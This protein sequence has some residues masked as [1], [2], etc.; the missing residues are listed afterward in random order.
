MLLKLIVFYDLYHWVGL[1]HCAANKIGMTEIFCFLQ[2]Q[3]TWKILR[4]FKRRR[5]SG[6]SLL[7]LKLAYFG[8][9]SNCMKSH[10]KHWHFENAKQFIC[11]LH[12]KYILF[13]SSDSNLWAMDM[14]MHVCESQ[15]SSISW[16]F[17][18]KWKVWIVPMW[19]KLISKFE[20]HFEFCWELNVMTTAINAQY[21]RFKNIYLI[22][23]GIECVHCNGHL[24]IE[25]AAAAYHGASKFGFRFVCAIGCLCHGNR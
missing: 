9:S 24:N 23:F 21:T 2:L 22:Q 10:K 12:C 8:F 17:T 1:E 16:E 18:R 6:I 20:N 7:S 19:V 5:I 3:W 4:L 25:C 15:C 13:N 11:L 14:H